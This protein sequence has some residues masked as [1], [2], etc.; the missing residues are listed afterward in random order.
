MGKLFVIIGKSATGKDTL[1][2]SLISMPE[3]SLRTFVSYTT[4]PIRSGETN[5][6][7]YFFSTKEELSAWQSQGKIIECRSYNTM[8]GVWDYFTVDDGQIDLTSS[9]YL[10]IMTLQGYTQ[11]L[12]FFPKDS[13]VPLYIDV[14]PGLR[15]QR[16][17]TRER[18]QS[19]PKYSEMCRRFLAD[20]ED[21]SEENIKQLEITKRYKNHK[22]ESCL[23]MLVRDILK[24][25]N[26]P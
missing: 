5:G 10:S 16:A 6:V 25:K 22:L 1:F 20:E 17:L 21:F 13:V 8:H 9:D 23:S 2:K 3:L 11:F 19:E 7:E 14:D 24:Y 26:T 12:S 18:R 15:L 4:R